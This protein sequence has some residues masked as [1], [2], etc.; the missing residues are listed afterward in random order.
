M[1]AANGVELLR[2]EDEAAD[3]GPGK[4]LLYA[5]TCRGGTLDVAYSHIRIVAPAAPPA[6]PAPPR[7]L[8]TRVTHAPPWRAPLVAVLSD[9]LARPQRMLRESSA[10]SQ[11]VFKGA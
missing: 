5:C 7:G 11:G 10:H 4:V 8:P 2:V 9:F 1:I 6:S 3:L